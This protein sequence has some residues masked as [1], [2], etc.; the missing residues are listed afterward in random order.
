M[1]RYVYIIELH[2]GSPVEAVC[3]NPSRAMRELREIAEVAF[4]SV[5]GSV[6]KLRGGQVACAYDGG[7]DVFA[8]AYRFPLFQ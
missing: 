1:S 3:S 2:N 5:S 7:G 4:G 8:C 6:S